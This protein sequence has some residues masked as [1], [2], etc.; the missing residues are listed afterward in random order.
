MSV[1][2]IIND[3]D[4]ANEF[5][6]FLKEDKPEILKTKDNKLILKDGTIFS[7]SEEYKDLLPK[8]NTNDLIY[9]KDNT[10]GI[11]SISVHKDDLIL[12]KY[13]GSVDVRKNTYWI[14]ASRKLDKD[15]KKLAGNQHY[16]FIRIF[17]NYNEY[18]KLI[19]KW[20]NADIYQ[21]WD[22]KEAALVFNGITF[23][24]GLTTND[25]S[26]LS[27][28]IEAEGLTHHEKSEVY[29]ITNTFRDRNNNIVRKHFRVD[30]YDN[31][32]DMFNDWCTWV[33]NI[34]PDVITGHNIYG[35][36]LP[37][38]DFCAKKYG[39]TL[40][41]GRDD[42]DMY[43]ST[44]KSL[45][46]VDG[47]TTWDY[48][49]IDIEGREVIDG[50]FLAVNY[51]IGRNY[52]SWGLKAIAEYEGFVKE[53]RQFYDAAKIKDNWH[54][55][56]EREKIVQYGIHDSDDSLQI[57][58]L[59]IPS[60]FYM[61]QSVPKTFQNMGTS[62]SGSQLNLI[63]VRAYLQD[64]HSIPKASEKE[65]VGGGM[66]YGIPGV[67]KNVVKW[68]AKS[69]Y[70]S[71][72]L[73]FDIY[74]KEKDPK[75]YFY[76]MVKHFTLKRFEQKDQY[77]KTQDKYYDDLQAASKVFIN[78]SYGV[79]GTSGL[80][81]NSFKNAQLITKCC[82]AGL[83]K[84]IKWATGRDVNYWWQG[85]SESETIKQDF[86]DYEY[87]D[88]KSEWSFDEMPRHDWNLVNIDTDSLSF[89][90]SDQTP[91]T[92]EEYKNVFKEINKIMYSE[93]EDDGEFDDVL[94]L[95][96]KNYVLREKGT[97]KLKYKGSSI[98]DSKKESA[99]T[100]FI[101]ML[102]DDL[103]LTKGQN[104]VD[105]YHKYIKEAYNI[106]DI[107]RWAKKISITKKVLFPER[108]NEQK[109]LDAVKNLNPREG[110]KFY[111][112]TAVNGEKQEVKNG[113]AVFLKSG[114]PK[115]I[116]NSILKVVNEYKEDSDKEH[117]LKRVYS[118]LEIFKN[119]LDMNNFIKYHLKSNISKV[120]NLCI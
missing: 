59:M 6:L 98:T 118:T 73:A 23:F 114:K 64:K 25:I 30:R 93:W 60:M 32:K 15:F 84:C 55:P 116:K 33:R 11:V 87:I 37:Y 100:E 76:K 81:F 38:M 117:Y 99:L 35:Y 58:D 2:Y 19:S 91:F 51:D 52:P 47:N 120:E 95:K 72:I 101:N 111:L 71:T 20:R 39:T 29:L 94:V 21:I 4:S 83:Q 34:N 16:N 62:A 79:L 78:S 106:K 88:N 12:Y 28:D 108:T 86:S 107:N 69:Y 57:F 1:E 22:K 109:V 7:L 77:K 26:V 46:R 54:N 97:D 66:S 41:L 43:I 85:Y 113:G 104:A 80:N 5:I 105:I 74:D 44:K 90:K 63:L 10:E 75:G 3:R 112:Y 65:Y 40:K 96:A 50:M 42:S 82:R 27:F 102:I 53:D 17:K 8:D 45:K 119:V 13:D 48:N 18:N 115:M 68:D 31:P 9:G 67:Y 61:N 110:D 36:D 56:I 24:K 70:P 92:E 103:L 89:C 49:K 14:L